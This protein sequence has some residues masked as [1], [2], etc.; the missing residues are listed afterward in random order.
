MHT[1]AA[2]DTES[3]VESDEIVS[4]VKSDDAFEPAT[5]FDARDTLGGKFDDTTVR[6]AVEISS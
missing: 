3:N 1:L 5:V 4:Q 2:Q 6:Q